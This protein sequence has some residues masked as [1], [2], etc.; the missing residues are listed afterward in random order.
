[1]SNNL[2][3]SALR[4]MK[5]DAERESRE[6]INELDKNFPGV[7]EGLATALGAGT[8]AAGSLAALSVLG[9]SG[10]SAAGITSGLAT[11]GALVGGGMVAGIGVLAAPIALLG[12]VGYG[13]AKKRKNTRL[14]TALGVAIRKLYS[15]QERLMQNAGY[16]RAFQSRNDLNTFCSEHAK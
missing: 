3:E 6:I 1:M 16:F 14:A 13:L 12:V 2:S 4:Q 7:T 11:A 8:G 9:V 10:L 15:I 5:S